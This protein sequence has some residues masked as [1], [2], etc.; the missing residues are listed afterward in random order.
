MCQ[1]VSGRSSD[2]EKF[3]FH[4]SGKSSDISMNSKFNFILNSLVGI[5]IPIWLTNG[6]VGD[7]IIGRAA[8]LGIGIPSKEMSLR[9]MEMY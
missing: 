9:K 4:V 6:G 2:R 7:G 3:R 5:G 1:G 8:R